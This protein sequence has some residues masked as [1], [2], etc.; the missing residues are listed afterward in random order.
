MSSP[1]LELE[2]EDPDDPDPER[3]KELK[4]LKAI[5][6]C[7]LG[8]DSWPGLY[9]NRCQSIAFSDPDRHRLIIK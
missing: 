1:S 8:L 2:S 6:R 9:P 5:K 3:K 4:V 7:W